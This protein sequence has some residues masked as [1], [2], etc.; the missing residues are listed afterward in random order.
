MCVNGPMFLCDEDRKLLSIDLNV[1]GVCRQLYE[2]A[3]HLLWATNTFSFEDPKT[4]GKFLGSLNPA[5]KRN[6]TSIH[7]SA[8]IG[9][10]GSYYYPSA[11]QRA[12]WDSDYWG[13]GLKLPHL[14]ML[15]GVQTLHLCINQKF[16]CVAGVVFGN[17]SAEEAVE[18]AQ[19]ADMESI[20]RLR[21]LEVRHVTVIVSDEAEKLEKLGRSAHRWTVEKKNKY[22]ESI[23]VQLMDPA[24]AELVKTQAESA[25]CTRNI[26]IRDNASARLASYKRNLTNKRADVVRLAKWASS[27][28]A[29]A[30][31]AARKANQV[32][33]KSS[34]KAAK[35]Q[36][37]A[38][39]QKER[40]VSVRNA[41]DAAVEKK[42]FWQEQVVNARQKYFRAM[43]RAGATA[44]DI[45]DEKELERLMEVSSGSEMDYSED[46]VV[47]TRRNVE[48]E[49][50]ESL[51]SPPE[52]EASDEDDQD[53]S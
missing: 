15:R 31:L 33:K 37:T 32:S 42:K 5:Q 28:E 7:I 35:L 10:L 38:K 13:K 41:L 44:D 11:A 47:Q 50:D 26:E 36:D 14:N 29:L 30:A 49:D 43:T 4:L 6:L 9:V 21:T 22:A 16:E 23:R 39:K 19:N 24:G 17:D 18:I 1:L 48:S 12:R 20:L 25:K 53:S 2:E 8:D 51:L 40:A 3:N 27:E 45:E 46:D 34:K 52:D